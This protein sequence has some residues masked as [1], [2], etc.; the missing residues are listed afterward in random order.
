MIGTLPYQLAA[1]LR[2][3]LE[4]ERAV[5]TGTFQGG[6]ARELAKMF[7]SVVTV[8]L[9]DRYFETAS[10]ALADVANVTI[11]HGSSPAVLST[12]PPAATLYWLDAHWSGLDTA[13]SDHPC[14]VLDEIVSIAPHPADC[15]L[16]DDARLFATTSEPERWPT[17]VAVIDALR[18][19]RPTSHV[20]VLHD[21]VICVPVE[22]KDLVD[23]FGKRHGEAVWAAGEQARLAGSE[24]ELTEPAEFARALRPLASSLGRLRR[25]ARRP[26][27]NPR[28]G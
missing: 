22:A 6:G 15:L 18:R 3:R 13:G 7:P 24:W 26:L 8:E 16:I 14:P 21:L 11:E 17:L 23:E 27:G 10:A 19:A 25:L 2:D 28:R 20:T 12:L 4:L 9:S 1:E 5:E